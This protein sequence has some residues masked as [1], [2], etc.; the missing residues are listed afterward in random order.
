MEL[1]LN[2]LLIDKPK[3]IT[4]FGVVN[5]F[6]KLLPR[7]AK[8]GH[9][10]TLDP[11]ATGLLLVLIGREQT[12]D[13]DKFMNLTKEY[14]A[15]IKFG[16]RTN[17]YDLDTNAVLEY[18]KNEKELADLDIEKVIN[19]VNKN[20]L[21]EIKQQVPAYSAVKVKGKKLYEQARKGVEIGKP[22]KQV[23]IDKFEIINFKNPFKIGEIGKLDE[24]PELNGVLTVSKGTYIRSIANDLGQNLGVFGVL[25]N[26]RR[27]RIGNYMVN[28]ALTIDEA[29]ALILNSF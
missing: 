28:D 25:S 20:F 29:K 11:V 14:E 4:S 15:E 19:E 8:I 1:T 23:V 10:G 6:K 26:L 18:T 7:G 9:A 17:T 21:G 13:Q 12:R 24:M 22:T 2:P 3:G 27:I 16:V 5:E